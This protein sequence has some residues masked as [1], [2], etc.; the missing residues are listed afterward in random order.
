MISWLRYNIKNKV[1]FNEVVRLVRKRKVARCPEDNSLITT[2]I[3]LSV[4]REL[5][6]LPRSRYLSDVGISQLFF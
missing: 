6:A 4:L 2:D 3:Y 5:K 1:E